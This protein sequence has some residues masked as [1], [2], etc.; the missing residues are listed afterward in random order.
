MHFLTNATLLV[1]IWN[2][3]MIFA[4]TFANTLKAGTRSI[5]GIQSIKIILFL[6]AIV[7]ILTG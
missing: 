7:L 5:L 6:L 2:G 1:I 3:L 4:G